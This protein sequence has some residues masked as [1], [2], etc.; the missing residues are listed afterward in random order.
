[1]K[2]LL[3]ILFVI[4]FISSCTKVQDE[5]ESDSVCLRCKDNRLPPQLE[6]W[7]TCELTRNQATS[8][9]LAM[10]PLKIECKEINN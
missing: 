10:I 3:L 5:P 4:L 1:M 7:D 8:F 2:T 6:T 9:I